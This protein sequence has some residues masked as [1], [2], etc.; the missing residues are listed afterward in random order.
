[1]QYSLSQSNKGENGDVVAY[2]NNE[3]EPQGKGEVF[4]ISQLDHLT[5]T[6]FTHMKIGLRAWFVC[7][8]IPHIRLNRPHH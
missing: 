8:N 2:T 6:S 5:C 3:D 4:H 7:P 1:M